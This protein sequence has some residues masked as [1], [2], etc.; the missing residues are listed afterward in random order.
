MDEKKFYDM[1]HSDPPHP[2]STLGK[3]IAKQ[4]KKV[5]LEK[6]LEKALETLPTDH[7]T[8]DEVAWLR[9]FIIMK[10]GP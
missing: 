6:K 7:L 5:T 1:I 3:Y 2:D 10:G 9:R 4:Q 8:E